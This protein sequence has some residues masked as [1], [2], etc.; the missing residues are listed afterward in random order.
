MAEWQ[1]ECNGHK[2]G[3]FREMVQTGEAWR[4][5]VPGAA[6]T[7]TRLGRLS[8]NKCMSKHP[9]RTEEIAYMN[10]RLF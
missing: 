5:A 3:H 7:W 9:Q 8:N 2:P 10:N 6:E 4:A 1:H